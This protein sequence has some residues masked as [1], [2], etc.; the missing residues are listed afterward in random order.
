MGK[1]KQYLCP[2]GFEF[3]FEVIEGVGAGELGVLIN[4]DIKAF[5][6]VAMSEDS[7]A[8]V[9]HVHVLVE[10]YSFEVFTGVESSSADAMD[11]VGEIELFNSALAES[12]FTYVFQVVRKS[13]K[14][15]V[16][17]FQE[18]TTSDGVN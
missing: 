16:V 15:K 17:A 10:D 1:R 8:N 5:E 2:E 6:F 7:G 18:G 4:S 9:V 3:T 13:D 12:P 14:F 11:D